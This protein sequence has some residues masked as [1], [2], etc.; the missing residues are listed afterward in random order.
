[1]MPANRNLIW[2]VVVLAAGVGAAWAF[3]K[4][5]PH[6]GSPP[7]GD[8]EPPNAVLIRRTSPPASSQVLTI[9]EPTS[10]SSTNRTSLTGPGARNAMP[11]DV[12]SPRSP[13][14]RDVAELPSSFADAVGRLGT[15]YRRHIIRDGDTLELLAE[16]YL[17]DAN[18]ADEIFELNGDALASRDLLPIGKSLKIPPAGAARLVPLPPLVPL[19]PLPNAATSN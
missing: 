17:G 8:T 3:R 12:L 4:D 10:R 7:L 16:R 11:T 13:A 6:L 5:S 9:E 18:R 2:G 1:M 15:T 19:K 14:R